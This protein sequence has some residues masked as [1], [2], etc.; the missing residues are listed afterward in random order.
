MSNA[1]D[2]ASSIRVTLAYDI[3]LAAF[4]A[5]FVGGFLWASAL[6]GGNPITPDILRI[7]AFGTCS[8]ILLTCLLVSGPLA[9]LDARF[10]PLA[11][12]NAHLA[13]A[14]ATAAL[15]HAVLTLNWY[16]DI[17]AL[18]PV[19]AL[20]A[21]NVRFGSLT[22]FPYELLGVA[23]LLLIF[24]VAA[25]GFGPWRDLLTPGVR[26][27]L[28]APAYAGYGL[29]VMHVALGAL[30]SEKSPIYAAFLVGSFVA[31][32]ALNLAAARRHRRSGAPDQA[33]RIALRSIRYFGA[34]LAVA[35]SLATGLSLVLAGAQRDP[36]L[37][38][39]ASDGEVTVSAILETAPYP[40]FTSPSARTG[41][42]GAR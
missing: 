23:T 32:A 36:G 26:C 40:S 3:V 9:R 28:R 34:A 21:D 22:G 33:S 8:L 24:V 2:A 10:E 27:A 31:V 25:A 37:G 12:R 7:R 15:V 6:P 5:L 19:V 17:G 13:A 14:T 16:H 35:L 4:I 20:L 18:N 41:G 42:L 38:A 11:A 30:Q 39:W 29:A 1:E